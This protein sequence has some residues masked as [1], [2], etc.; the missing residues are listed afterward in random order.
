MKMAISQ[1][2]KDKKKGISNRVNAIKLERGCWHCGYRKNTRALTFAHIHGTTKYRTK[3]TNAIVDISKMVVLGSKGS[4]YSE[5]TIMT[6]IAKC[7]VL[8]KNCHDEYDFPEANVK[9]N[10]DDI[11]QASLG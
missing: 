11:S 3:T 2:S 5:K 6:E 4:R 8:C 9:E 1:Q 10:I 7:M